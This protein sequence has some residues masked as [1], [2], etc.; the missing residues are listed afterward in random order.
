LLANLYLPGVAG[1]DVVRAALLYRKVPDKARL[2]LGSLADRLV[3]TV[4]LL[5]MG[6]AGLLYTVGRFESGGMLLIWVCIALI[7]LSGGGIVAVKY[8]RLLLRRLPP[9]GRAARVGEQLGASIVVLSGQK[10][11]LVLCLALS[12]LVQCAFVVATIGLANA[13]EVHVPV[14][15]WF[16]AWPLSKLIATLPISIAGLG[17]REASLAGFLA[18]FGAPAATI[19]GVGLLWQT[20]QLSGALLGG[21]FVLISG[22]A[23]ADGSAPN[24]LEADT[25]DVR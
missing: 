6:A 16:F 20:I 23:F 11:R 18:P 24:P 17:V 14:A 13:A 21:L 7:V 8:H 25:N 4:A 3:D 12:L 2:A 5:L 10:I 15:A 19:V 1:G 9:Q 22:Y